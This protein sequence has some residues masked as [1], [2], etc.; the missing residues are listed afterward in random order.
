MNGTTLVNI[1]STTC[2]CATGY[3]FNTTANTCYRNCTGISGAIVDPTNSSNCVCTATGLSFTEAFNTTSGLV[4]ACGINCSQIVSTASQTSAT[5]CACNTGFAWDST[6]Y[7]CNLDCGSIVYSTGYVSGSTLTCK[8]GT[9]YR[10]DPLLRQ[11]IANYHWTNPAAIA[12]PI[13]VP[14]GV[15]GLLGLLA[16]LF[17]CLPLCC[18]PPTPIPIPIPTPTPVGTVAAQPVSSVTQLIQPV[19]QSQAYLPKIV[20]G[21]PFSPGLQNLIAPTGF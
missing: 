3:Y 9:R 2:G 5:V 16:S 20:S 17:C 14:L 4:G 21:A 6:N 19:I 18:R 12:I 11:C 10:W 13:A 15:L 1:N 7:R 8:C